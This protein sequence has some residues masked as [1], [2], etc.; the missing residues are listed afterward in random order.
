MLFLYIFLS[1]FLEYLSSDMILQLNTE[2]LEHPEM[3]VE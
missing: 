2:L 1:A 3:Q